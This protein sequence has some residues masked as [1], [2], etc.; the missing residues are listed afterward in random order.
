MTRIPNHT[1]QDAPEASRPLL[2][3]T[4][5]FSPAGN[6]INVFSRPPATEP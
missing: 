3:G 4:V 2:E 1:I 5:Q 6:L